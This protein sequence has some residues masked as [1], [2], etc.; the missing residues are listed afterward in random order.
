MKETEDNTNQRRQSLC[1]WTGRNSTVKMIMLPK[2]THPRVNAV[3]IKIRMAFSF[4]R[5]RTNNSKI[6]RKTQKTSNSQKNLEKEQSW[7]YTVPAF[8]PYYKTT[9]FKA[10]WYTHAHMHTCAHTHT[11]QWNRRECPVEP[12]LKWAIHVQQRRQ[13]YTMSERLPLQ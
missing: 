7:K 3:P 10:V 12:I 2:A 13:K 1:S 5:A 8:K 9:V 6:C 4:H 11:Q